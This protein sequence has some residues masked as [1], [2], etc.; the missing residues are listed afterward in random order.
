MCLALWQMLKESVWK[1][2]KQTN[3]TTHA[4]NQKKKKGKR[5]RGM[6]ENPYTSWEPQEVLRKKDLEGAQRGKYHL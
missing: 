2:P 5:K 4:Q 3:K 1:V 6:G